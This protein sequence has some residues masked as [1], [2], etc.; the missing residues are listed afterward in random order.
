MNTP[1]LHLIQRI[2]MGHH[3]HKGLMVKLLE[4]LLHRDMEQFPDQEDHPLMINISGKEVHQTRTLGILLEVAMKNGPESRLPTGLRV[5]DTGARLLIG[6]MHED[7]HLE[8]TEAQ[9][10][11]LNTMKRKLRHRQ[12]EDQELHLRGCLVTLCREGLD[13]LRLQLAPCQE[14]QDPLVDLEGQPL[15]DQGE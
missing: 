8:G 7:P 14:E 11:R 10:L 15:L 2:P 5:Q 13:P 1:I 9:D 12:L 6:L 3:H 4:D